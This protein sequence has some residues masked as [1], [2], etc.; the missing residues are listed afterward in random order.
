VFE[1]FPVPHWKWEL[2]GGAVLHRR[3]VMPH[4][5]REEFFV[6]Y[7][8]EPSEK[9]Q[10]LWLSFQA[11][12]PVESDDDKLTAQAY[13]LARV[14]DRAL[15]VHST[16]P[17]RFNRRGEPLGPV[18]METERLCDD[19]FEE[20]MWTGP[21]LSFEV[22]AGE[23]VYLCFSTREE[24]EPAAAAEVLEKELQRRL[25]LPVPQLRP[26]HAAHAQHLAHAADQFLVRSECARWTIIAGYPWFTDWGRDTM[27][28]LRGL[29]RV[30]RY[31]NFG[32]L[33]IERFLEY[34][35]EGLIP[36]LFPETG[37][38]PEYNTA[39]AT[40]WLVDV[41]FR[42]WR[43]EELRKEHKS[44]PWQFGGP[45]KMLF[46]KGERGQH[47]LW[48]ALKE[49]IAFKEKGTAGHNIRLD[50]DGLL[51]AGTPGT[52]LTWMD[53]KVNGE[54]PTP[55]HGKPVEIQGLWYNALRLMADAAR[56]I[57]ERQEAE[58]YEA[59][60]ARAQE[61]FAKRYLSTDREH[62][63]DVIDRD[64][65]GDVDW[66]I[67]PN[68]VIPFWLTHNIIPEEK[69]ADVLRVAARELVTPRGL[70]SLAPG[71]KKYRGIYQGNR[72]E[73]DRAYH[74]GT[75]WFWLLGPYVQGVRQERER[76]PELAA[77]LPKL[78]KELLY[79]FENEGCLNQAS[80]VFDGNAPHRPSGCFAQ[81]WSIAALVD[82][83]AKE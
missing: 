7:E 40:L 82:V 54:V 12:L 41:F 68:M 14:E 6:C 70:R 81:A 39:D 21:E 31:L 3:L 49:I 74:Q 79:H 66:S 8:I 75:V 64:T 29:K 73:R 62:I 59:M 46:P 72:L 37:E 38:E 30:P 65:P 55:R 18:V 47:P 69:R 45:L 78:I 24:C 13:R 20:E 25:T 34:E 57:G 77:E 32:R 2:E 5:S 63:A 58:H 36:N 60:A 42:F 33:I 4:G 26:E 16:E 15:Y 9:Q 83:L 23:S 50:S 76:V 44:N 56:A 1:S 51:S 67:R 19:E 71:E 52:Q 53:V 35:K 80:E 27:I 43:T 22:R 28:S 48:N 17:F 10:S 11:V 61:S